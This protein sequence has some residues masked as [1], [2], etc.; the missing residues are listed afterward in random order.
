M[1]AVARTLGPRRASDRADGARPEPASETEASRPRRDAHGRL[2]ESRRVPL[3]RS[4]ERDALEGPRL[5][6][7]TAA[8]RPSVA[9]NRLRAE[10]GRDE[11]PPQGRRRRLPRRATRPGAHRRLGRR[12]EVR[13]RDAQ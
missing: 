7:A 13:A 6:P 2:S 12:G 4:L 10:P 8:R 3:A 5:R 9:P 1:Y 11:A